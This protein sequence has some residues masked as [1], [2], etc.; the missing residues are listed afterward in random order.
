MLISVHT[1]ADLRP[2]RR[3]CC[4]RLCK[5][6]RAEDGGPLHRL[7]WDLQRKLHVPGCVPESH[8]SAGRVLCSSSPP[9]PARLSPFGALSISRYIGKEGME[10]DEMK[11]FHPDC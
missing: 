11:Y 5:H 10:I 7:R 4:G 8:M 1:I 3:L 9:V 6:R 2:K